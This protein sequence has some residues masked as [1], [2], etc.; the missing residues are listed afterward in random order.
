MKKIATLLLSLVINLT[1]AQVNEISI[2]E[3][4]FLDSL[5]KNFKFL[6]LNSTYT[7]MNAKNRDGFTMD[8]LFYFR[9]N[10]TKN[11]NIRWVPVYTQSIGQEGKKTLQGEYAYSSLRWYVNNILTE[12]K[13][14]I[15]LNFQN[16]NYIFDGEDRNSGYDSYHRAYFLS[17]KTVA[18]GKLTLEANTYLQVYNKNGRN[19]NAN[20]WRTMF[21]TFAFYNFNDNWS[22]GFGGEWYTDHRDGERKSG[23]D[24]F[25]AWLPYLRYAKG[26]GYV[27]LYATYTA[28]QS[29]DNDHAL[30]IDDFHKRGTL[31][32][33]IG[34][35]F[36]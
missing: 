10:L 28:A 11:Q 20:T 6:Y 30:I 14:G 36:F 31:T 32:L 34:Y 12:D 5:S 7:E 23:D 13:H 1:Y 4:S 18:D 22:L 3:A 9:Y 33:D 8:H 19:P 21:G 24:R 16:R 25:V 29:G 15:N 2:E 26:D 35:Y 17:S 27:E